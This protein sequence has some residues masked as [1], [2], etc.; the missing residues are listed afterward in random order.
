MLADPWPEKIGLFWTVSSKTFQLFDLDDRLFINSERE[1]QK[2]AH[3]SFVV[4]CNGEP[5]WVTLPVSPPIFGI[6]TPV[7]TGR[8][9]VPRRPE[10][11]R[12]L[13]MQLN[14]NS[15]FARRVEKNPGNI[16]GYIL[17]DRLEFMQLKPPI[18]ILCWKPCNQ[19]HL[20]L[21]SWNS[22]T[23]DYWT[24]EFWENKG[25]GIFKNFK[26]LSANNQ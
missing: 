12:S 26:K 22:E 8:S 16:F 10:L 5:Y 1:W 24:E 2:G 7:E 3:P 20:M 21:R 6:H 19:K 4:G 14:H 17:K 9:A 23:P 15:G 25:G 11:Y 18:S 13:E